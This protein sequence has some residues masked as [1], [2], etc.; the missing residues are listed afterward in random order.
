MRTISDILEEQELTQA[1]LA[2]LT[3]LNESY[4]SRIISGDRELKAVT[5]IVKIAA[6][7]GISV[8]DL[9]AAIE[10]NE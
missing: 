2:R 5:T 10:A 3:G 8:E 9:V 7:L 6:T 4:I 1:D